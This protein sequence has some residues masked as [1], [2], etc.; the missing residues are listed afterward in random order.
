[1]T[2]PTGEISFS[3]VRDEL[4]KMGMIN[5]DD[6]D[7]RGLAEKLNGIISMS[8]LQGKSAFHW[9]EILQAMMASD[10]VTGDFF[11]SSVA[12]DG[13]RLVVGA[14][15]RD[16]GGIRSRGK[17]YVYD[18]NGS[19]YVETT[20]V[21]ASDAVSDNQFGASVALEGD[22]LVVGARNRDDYRGKVYVYVW[23]GTSYVEVS[24]LLADDAVVRDFFG[25]AVALEDN[26]LIVG[27]VKRDEGGITDRGKVYVYDWNS[28]TNTYDEVTTLL[29]NDAVAS[30]FFG[31]SVALE[32]NRLIVGARNRDEGGITD[33]GKVYVYDWNS[34]TNTYDE[35]TT[36]L[37][38]DAVTGDF[39]GSSVALDG[40]R[41]VVGAIG[42]D[43]GGI[44]NRG[45]V[46]VYVWNGTSYVETTTL[47]ASDGVVANDY[48]GSSVSL[49]GNRL[50]VGALSRD[51]GGIV[52]IGKVHVYDYIRL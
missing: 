1:M 52:N 35:V 36:L 33:R 24:T 11:G 49:D 15:G 9:A 25:Y 32:G 10:A 47:L 41:L 27:A 19:A 2:L 29:A 4:E 44:S 22:R 18:W 17:V 34:S 13:N 28:S 37:A 45:K 5:L 16:D 40:N 21:V 20:T 14:M 8:D 51:E 38:N 7:V 12:L 43:D 46:Y 50:V 31:S 42:R 23:N 3:Q 30:D 48:F 39:F 6:I 26:R